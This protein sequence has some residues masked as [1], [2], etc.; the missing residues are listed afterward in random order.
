MVPLLTSV[1]PPA[2]APFIVSASVAVELEDI[3]TPVP[4]VATTAVVWFQPA[5]IAAVRKFTFAALAEMVNVKE[6]DFP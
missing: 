2:Q 6:L 1:T 3:T 4:I 5:A